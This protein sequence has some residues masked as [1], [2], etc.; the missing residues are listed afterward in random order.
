MV[1]EWKTLREH[2]NLAVTSVPDDTESGVRV[3]GQE[4]PEVLDL[5]LFG[6]DS[7]AAGVRAGSLKVV[8]NRQD[9][10]LL[11]D[12]GPG[13]DIEK[14]TLVELVDENVLIGKDIVG[15]AVRFDEVGAAYDQRPS[16]QGALFGDVV[17]MRIGSD[18]EEIDQPAPEDGRSDARNS[19]LEVY[20]LGCAARH[21]P[22]DM[23][24]SGILTVRTEGS[25]LRIVRAIRH[26]VEGPWATWSVPVCSND[27]EGSTRD[28]CLSRA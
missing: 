3:L 20:S 12:T 5:Y 21:T 16:D 19:L 8:G 7:I 14:L 1:M 18:A 26:K 10:E 24:D 17:G 22:Q 25:M 6:G 28:T 11:S 27:L 23:C 13:T 15:T 2:L 4:L 9:M